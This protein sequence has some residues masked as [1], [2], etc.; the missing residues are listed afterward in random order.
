LDGMPDYNPAHA[1]YWNSLSGTSA[2][3]KPVSESIKQIIDQAVET[4]V[5]PE[6]VKETVVTDTRTIQD[7]ITDAVRTAAGE[8]EE[9][10]SGF[11]D[12]KWEPD[13][14]DFRSYFERHKFSPVHAK[15]LASFYQDDLQDLS[16]IVKPLTKRQVEELDQSKREQYEQIRE[17]YSN[18]TRSQIQ[19]YHSALNFVVQECDAFS[20][21]QR[22][23]KTTKR[24]TPQRIDAQVSKLKYLANDTVH[25]L[26][27]VNPQSIIGSER[28]WVYNTKTRK[29]GCYVAERI[30]PTG[31]KRPGS[32][33]GVKGTT[34]TGFDTESS[35]QKTVR[36]PAE[37]LR[38]FNAANKRQLA[39]FMDTL[40]TVDSKMNGR[41][42][43]DTILLRVS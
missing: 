2:D 4:G 31:S 6:P 9:W 17:G 28:L 1:E 33:L 12:T 10:L 36:K 30:D 11:K 18:L 40:T 39:K 32:G 14:F 26:T 27:S 21:M 22:A 23:V 20:N 34:V 19:R 43:S 16:E 42:N 24:V 35:I 7:R 37:T 13:Q 41:I 5:I 15:R 38:E 8:V 29:L 3:L 25:G